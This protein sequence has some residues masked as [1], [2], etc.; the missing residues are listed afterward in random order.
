[1]ATFPDGDRRRAVR[2]GA[3]VSAAAI[4]ILVLG[5]ISR[6]R[7]HTWWDIEPPVHPSI[8]GTVEPT[9]SRLMRWRGWAYEC[10]APPGEAQE[11]YA[12]ELGAMGWAAGETRRLGQATLARYRRGA[13]TLEVRCERIA[14]VT[15]VALLLTDVA[16][17]SE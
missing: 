9:H 12:T 14:D 2:V 3:V 10:T 15:R 5:C 7:R 11:F 8:R 4:L 13:L 16:G 1:M 17:S 6:A